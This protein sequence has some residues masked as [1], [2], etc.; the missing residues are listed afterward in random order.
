MKKKLILL[1]CVYKILF[2]ND[3]EQSTWSVVHKKIYAEHDREHNGREG[4]AFFSKVHTYPFTQLIL[5]WNAEGDEDQLDFFVRLRVIS[6]SKKEWDGWHKVATWS[7]KLRRSF[8]NRTS[9]SV[10]HYVRLEVNSSALG[11][12]FEIKVEGKSEA[13]E[14]LHGL[15]V[16]TSNLFTMNQS[17]SLNKNLNKYL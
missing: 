15:F 13:L 8:F 1:L 3:K 2:G 11:I 5:C 17:P 16:C 7:K 6:G 12:G 9:H 10:N 14:K 4:V